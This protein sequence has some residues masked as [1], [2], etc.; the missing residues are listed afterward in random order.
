MRV[1]QIFHLFLNLLFWHYEYKIN[2]NKCNKN[3]LKSQILLNK[4]L[5]NPLI[6]IC[7]I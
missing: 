1:S 7:K 3:Q 4:I 5:N 6:I 2:K